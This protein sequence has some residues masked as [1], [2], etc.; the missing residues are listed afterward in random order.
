MQAPDYFRKTGYRNPIDALHRP[1]Q[2][3]FGTELAFF[4][5]LHQDPAQVKLFN[6]FMMGNRHVRHH[7]VD[8]FPVRK[9]I[10]DGFSEAKMMFSWLTLEVE[11][12]TI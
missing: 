4:E 5:Y 1:F 10:L 6:T 11:A 2:Y 12:A 9:H 7:W 8:W 3:A